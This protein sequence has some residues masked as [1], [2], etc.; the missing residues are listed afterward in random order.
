MPSLAALTVLTIA[1]I[2]VEGNRK[3]RDS[4]VREISDLAVGQ[5]WS[6][7]AR[8]HAKDELVTSGLFKDVQIHEEAVDGGIRVILE[9][10]DKH[11]WIIAPTFYNQ[12]T[13]KGGG[14]GFGENNLLGLNQKLLLYA[15]YAT[16]DSF[17]IGAYIDPRFLGTRWSWQ[18]DIYLRSSRIIEYA[19]PIAWFDDPEPVRESRLQYLNA[20]LKIGRELREGATLEGR[21]RA[22]D[23]SYTDVA[24]AEGATIE[25]VGGAPGDE[26]PAPG[27]PGLDTTFEVIATVDDRTNYWGVQEG[28][29]AVITWEH[30]LPGADFDYWYAGATVQHGITFQW[31]HNVIA[32]GSIGIGEDLPFQ[33]EYSIGGT[34]HRGLENAQLRGDFRLSAGLEYSAPVTTYRG[35]AIR[36]LTFVDAG[37][38]TFNDIEADDDFRHYLPGAA[39]DGLAPYKTSV[40]IGTRLYLRQVV[41]PLLGL[42]FGYGVERR[43]FEIYLAIG[44]VD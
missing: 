15:Q 24:L 4:T 33:Q 31:N 44:L 29:K 5:P 40:G 18:L 13:N 25:D 19:A 11:S 16:G 30:S 41:L 12:P 39:A 28:T 14:L 20:G 37:Y 23:V 17:F 6:D 10:R 8:Q 2:V 34:G 1:E 7:R 27:T 9:V 22:A 36:G 3:T 21:V 42:D 38:V 26:V 32:R 43:A 35:V